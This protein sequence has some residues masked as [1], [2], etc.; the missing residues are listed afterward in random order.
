M[1]LLF[2]DLRKCHI[3]KKLSE[4]CAIIESLKETFCACSEAP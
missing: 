2:G 4:E 3:D 1:V